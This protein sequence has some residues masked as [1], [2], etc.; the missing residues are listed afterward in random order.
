M[1]EKKSG[2]PA[3]PSSTGGDK[4]DDKKGGAGGEETVK[5]WNDSEVQLLKKWGETAASYRLLHDRAY[6]YYEARAFRYN[7]PIIILS[8]VTGTASFSQ[9]LFPPSYQPFVPM[10]I[11]SLNIFTGILGTLSRFYRLDEL[12]ESHR[13]ASISYGKYARNIS[14]ELSLP[15]TNRRYNG[16][17]MVEMCRTE[18]DRLIEQSPII[19]MF[20]LMEFKNNT[21]F[22]FINKPEVLDIKPIEEYK[23]SKEEKVVEIVTSVVERLKQVKP[24]KTLVQQMAERHA[25]ATGMATGQSGA[26]SKQTLQSIVHNA[27][28]NRDGN[29]NVFNQSAPN[30]YAN[31]AL[32]GL[33]G[34]G[35]A[36]GMG[37]GID[38]SPPGS[39]SGGGPRPPSFPIPLNSQDRDRAKEMMRNVGN[40]GN[41]FSQMESGMGTA[42][43]EALNQVTESVMIPTAESLMTKADLLV[44]EQRENIKSEIEN[45][46]TPGTVSA[47][48]T[49]FRNM[50]K[51]A[52]SRERLSQATKNIVHT[53]AK[54]TVSNMMNEVNRGM[55]QTN[56]YFEGI[57]EVKDDGDGGNGGDGGGGDGGDGGDGSGGDENV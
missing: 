45:V 29:G 40:V 2:A 24:E 36:G 20:I 50:A 34:M 32:V 21:E 47:A 12:T 23:M 7:V 56:A 42:A 1:T 53:A 22:K 25:V 52:V 18:M 26:P 33:P 51:K 4:K 16:A 43:T 28:M 13:V 57:E 44:A 54:S 41:V 6:R 39:G 49:L 14:T 55:T 5:I 46:I 11:G 35:G 48:K 37:G 30:P 31:A 10:V 17:D 15:P 38:R 9:T 8:T 3:P 19:P 27:L